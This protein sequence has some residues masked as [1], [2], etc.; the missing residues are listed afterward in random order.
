[1]E[2][3][4]IVDENDNVIGQATHDDIYKNKHN[5][6]IVH[7]MIFDDQGRIGLQLRTMNKSFAPGHWSTIVGGHVQ[8]GE[9]YLE[10]AKREMMEEIWIDIPLE[11]L[12]CDSYHDIDCSGTTKFLTTY[13]AVY[14]GPFNPNPEDIERLEFFSPEEIKKMIKNDEKFHPE[15][16]FLLNKI[17]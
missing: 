10:G 12:F 3:L 14:N 1:M 2:Y 8:A 6:R 7:V 11:E 17:I 4:D 13:K 5:H 9:T 16:L 15:L